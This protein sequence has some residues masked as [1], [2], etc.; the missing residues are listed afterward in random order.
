MNIKTYHSD[1]VESAIRQARLELG[2]NAM[3]LDS[4]KLAPQD[5]RSGIYEVRFALPGTPAP[6]GADLSGLSRGLEEIR[7]MLHTFTYKYYL[8]AAGLGPHPVLGE[9]YRGLIEAE[10]EPEIA[11]ELVAGL[12]PAAE[13]RASRQDLDQELSAELAAL[14][15]VS[16]EIGC[17]GHEPRAVALVGPPG[18]GKTTTLAKIAVQ[19]GLAQH[20]PPCLVTVD[21][22]RVAAARQLET[23]AS[24]LEVEAKTV[25][26]PS[27]LDQV[28]AG[29][30][31]GG[32]GLVLIDTPGLST[33]E[34]EQH[35][36]EL[37]QFLRSHAGIDV[38]LVLS[39]STK[40]RDLRRIVDCYWAFGP[41]K[42]L[43]TKLDE[44]LSLGPL[45]NEAVRTRL[46]LSFLASGQRIPEDLRPAARQELAD[47]IGNRRRLAAGR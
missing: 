13:R 11:A 31:P 5:R 6:A 41:R 7:Q 14:F 47:G 21:D 10:V 29:F 20:R 44:T 30:R 1:S 22:Y 27:E 18:A 16:D 39:A 37:S 12:I 34:L 4:R 8:P 25:A 28:L 35:A 38:H 33:Q 19:F 26:E 2:E 15:E 23:F 45:L 36:G 24:L 3:L 9:L 32:P 42:L 43:F 46:P 17:P 40:P